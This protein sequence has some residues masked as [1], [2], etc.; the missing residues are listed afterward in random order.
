MTGTLRWLGLRRGAAAVSGVVL[1]GACF[2]GLALPAAGQ[3]A[4]ETTNLALTCTL[5][6]GVLNVTTTL[7][8]SLGSNPTAVQ[9]GSTFSARVTAT[10]TVPP[11]WQETLGALGSVSSTVSLTPFTVDATGATPA[12]LNWGGSSI[13]LPVGTVVNGQ[14]TSFGPVT[15]TGGPYTVT[16][17]EGDQVAFSLDSTQGFAFSVTGLDADGS[18]IGPLPVDCTPP[19]ST[20]FETV[21]IQPAGTPPSPTLAPAPDVSTT[22]GQTATFT[23]YATGSPLPTVQWQVSTDGGATWKN[24]T[25]DAVTTVPAGN[26]PYVISTLTVSPTTLAE[27]GNRY[28]PVFTNAAGTVTGE[29]AKLTVTQPTPPPTIPTVTRVAPNGGSAYSLVLINGTN[30]NHATV[31]FG[32]K[33]ALSLVLSPRMII[34]LAPAQSPGTVNVTVTTKTGTSAATSADQFTYR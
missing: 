5:D 32:T 12:V 28:Q 11:N 29:S 27:N 26:A 2:A 19:S 34:A 15:L 20:P 25:T 3:A 21:P 33:Q 4:P 16:G 22:P 17:A 30:F 13:V 6:P 31:S 7:D 9:P 18:V 23:D 1:A 8:V 14:P 10:F 24:D